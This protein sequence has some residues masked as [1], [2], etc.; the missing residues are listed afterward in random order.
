MK[1]VEKVKFVIDNN[2]HMIIATADDR[3]K[4][5]ISPVFFV[6]DEQYNLYWVSYK[7]ALHSRNVRVKAQV[8]IVI[9]GPVPP[10]GKID[11]VYI[12][13]EANELED[14]TAIVA[15][16]RVLAGHIQED[17]Y[18]IKGIS[19]VS[20]EAAWRIYKAVPITVSKRTENGEV[21]NG[22][23]ITTREIIELK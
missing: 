1:A 11:A 21:I 10:E 4:P 17:K 13:A 16:M 23:H 7:D 12:D 22:Q 8:A 15:A 5:W 3:G 19:D 14:E 18:M 2:I 20:G 6:H 9:F